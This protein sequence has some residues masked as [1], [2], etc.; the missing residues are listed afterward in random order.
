MPADKTAD[1]EKSD[2]NQHNTILNPA[3]SKTSHT[4]WHIQSGAAVLCWPV[5]LPV[6]GHSINHFIF[7][8]FGPMANRL[9]EDFEGHGSGDIIRQAACSSIS[10]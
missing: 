1:I 10:Q 9:L 8:S 4:G 7:W 2:P 3:L 5:A 6:D